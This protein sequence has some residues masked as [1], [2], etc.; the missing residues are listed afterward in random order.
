M[1]KAALFSLM[2]V[3]A[4]PYVSQAEDSPSLTIRVV[5]LPWYTP[6]DA[7]IY[8]SS[9]NA[10]S[11]EEFRL[12]PDAQGQYSVSL[13]YSL[14]S[15]HLYYKLAL[16]QEASVE[17]DA[18]GDYLPL[19]H[20][21]IDIY[22]SQTVELSV[23]RW[24]PYRSHLLRILITTLSLA[25]G[26]AAIGPI[27]FSYRRQRRPQL[28]APDVDVQAANAALAATVSELTAQSKELERWS[29]ACRK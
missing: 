1:R 23:S 19:R 11:R 10:N 16:A 9:G 25:L 7:A 14:V 24:E 12:K 13:P 26:L 5:K 20:A 17:T 21:W 4:S 18:H 22:G 27:A 29:R 3:L 8:V 28:V 6:K 2:L 15:G